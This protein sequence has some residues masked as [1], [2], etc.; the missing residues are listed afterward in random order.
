MSDPFAGMLARQH[1][2]ERMKEPGFAKT[3]ASHRPKTTGLG[4]PRHEELPGR[5]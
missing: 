4:E 2:D 3:A 1:V 5:S